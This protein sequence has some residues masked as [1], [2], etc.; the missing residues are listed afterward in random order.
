[1]SLKLALTIEYFLVMNSKRCNISYDSE[2]YL[3]FARIP[4]HLVTPSTTQFLYYF[5][6]YY[7][8]LRKL[9]NPV[10]IKTGEVNFYHDFSILL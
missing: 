7:F 8:L 3:Q 10:T 4:Y 1:M 2:L 5:F 6:I 9:D